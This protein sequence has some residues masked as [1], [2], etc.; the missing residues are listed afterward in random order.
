M[1]NS[2]TLHGNNMDL[3]TSFAIRSRS[4]GQEKCKYIFSDDMSFV[5][6]SDFISCGRWKVNITISH[7]IHV[8]MF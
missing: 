1:G 2:S 4:R 8:I 7:N 6:S 5:R 3:I